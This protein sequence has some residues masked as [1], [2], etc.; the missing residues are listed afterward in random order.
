MVC[1]LCFISKSTDSLIVNHLEG[2]TDDITWQQPTSDD[3]QTITMIQIVPC[4]VEGDWKF[5]CRVPQFVVKGSESII[6]K[7]KEFWI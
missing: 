7:F 1:R 5:S 3:I 2:K 4:P 6:E